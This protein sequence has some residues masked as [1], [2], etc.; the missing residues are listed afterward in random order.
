MGIR[1]KF[2]LTILIIFIAGFLL[3]GYLV[4]GVLLDNAKKEVALNAN[5]MMAAAKSVRS[6]TVEEI[7]PL[8]NKLGKDEFLAQTVPAY[9]ATE[10]MK[11]LRKIYPDYTYK[12][13]ALNPTNPEHKAAGWEEDVIQYFRTYDSVKEYSGVRDT[14]TGQYLFLSRPFKIT[15]EGCLACHDSPDAAPKSMI[16]K[17]GRS[18][19]FGWKH[20]EIIGAQIVNVPMSIPLQ[21]ANE[22]LSTFMI[23]LGGVFAVIWL[24]LN[25]MLY[26][27]IIKRI[28]VIS[29]T[30]EKISKGDMSS[31][32]FAMKGKDEIDSLSRSFNLM[33]RSLCSAVKLLDKTQAG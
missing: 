4:K 20:N 7:R 30:A 1:F 10:S 33:Y 11:R 29:V 12:E 31:P 28:D 17:Y 18:N 22:A 6:Y 15:K 13:A 25:L 19:G 9:A 23:I 27:I 14:P 26:L 2:N 8:L 16:K 32:E 21:R 24:A 5:I 3:A